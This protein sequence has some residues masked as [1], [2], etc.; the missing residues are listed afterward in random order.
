MSEP[1]SVPTVALLLE[2]VRGIV[3]WD[4]LGGHLGLESHEIKE[5][6]SNYPLVA[7]R[8]LEMLDLWL[9]RK[10]LNPSWEKIITALQK[11]SELTLAARLQKKYIQGCQ[12]TEKPG[13][14]LKVHEKDKVVQELEDI[15]G[16][17]LRLV[18]K[19]E[20]ALEDESIP[21]RDLRRF[22]KFYL[23]RLELV[24]AVSTVEELFDKLAPY[25]CFLNYTL[26]KRAINMFLKHTELGSHLSDYQQLLEEFKK[27]TTLQ[28]FMENIERAQ[29]LPGTVTDGKELCTVTIRLVGGWL[30]KTVQNL[31]R[32]VEELF[33]DKSSVLAHLMICPGSII[34]TY[35][36]PQLEA[37]SL[38]A[39]AREKVSFMSQV[40][41]CGLQVGETVVTSMQ[42]GTSPF[43][44]ESSLIGAVENDDLMLLS[45]LLDLN[46]SPDAAG[47]EE[48]QTALMIGSCRGKFEAVN[49]LLKANADPNLH[50]GDGKTALFVASQH[51][52][53]EVVR[54]LLNASANPNLPRWDGATALFMASQNGHS[55]AV[56]LLLNANANPNLRWKDG[57]TALAMASL[58]GHSQVVRLLLRSNV[59]CNPN[60]QADDGTS[61]LMMASHN[62]HTEIVDSLLKGNANPNL[63]MNDGATALH[64]AGLN[65]LSEIVSLLLKADADPNVRRH[66]GATALIFASGKG[67]Q[68]IVHRLLRAKANTS[69]KMEHGITA[70]IFATAHK[71]AEVVDLLLSADADPN[72]RTNDGA[73]ALHLAT[74]TGNPQIVT[75]LLKAN[76][77]PDL[78][79]GGQGPTALILASEKGDI[80][81]VD[82]LLESNA[83]PNIPSNSGV[84]ALFM[85][86]QNGHTEVV[87][88]LLKANANPD[89]KR[90]L[91]VTPLYMASQKGYSEIVHLL[92]K[93]NANPNL[94]TDRGYTALSVASFHGHL[95]VVS[96]LLNS[97]AN[98][99]LQ[100]D[101]GDT[102]LSVASKNG[103]L[104]VVT[105]LL[106][107]SVSDRDASPGTQVETI[108]PNVNHQGQ[109]GS[110]A[111]M[112]A[113]P[114][115]EVVE[116]LLRHGAKPNIQDKK[117]WT[118]LMTACQDG[119][120]ETAELLLTSGADPNLQNHIGATALILATYYGHQDTVD[121]LQAMELSLFSPVPQDDTLKKTETDPESS[122]VRPDDDAPVVEPS[123]V[124]LRTLATLV[125]PP[126]IHYKRT[127]SNQALIQEESSFNQ[128]M[129]II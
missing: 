83:N 29:R 55:E 74:T 12:V 82:L 57:T 80:R 38:I 110:T 93:S 126:A 108:T 44:F 119:N 89:L 69:F 71:H 62:G 111:L 15:E 122:P 97:N 117:G 64:L 39:F 78:R 76:A 20:S 72:Q 49:L 100:A 87:R 113:H 51:G 77:N 123:S 17:F 41:I 92:L 50:K 34:V 70:L 99:N 46:T 129:I 8:R 98:P 121:L 63:Q 24:A 73:T 75:L 43:S 91:G 26:L 30:P 106:E 16:E 68:N 94:Q 127:F 32:L 52:H 54:L 96:Q 90:D 116:V 101:D 21:M 2:E 14:D 5:I 6:E 28:Q 18:V 23:V 7:R 36:A 95:E 128:P 88:L 19:I 9:N 125:Q 25:Y 45:F 35:F 79:G 66:D 33:Q 60:H 58:K 107:G 42:N 115:P 114:H 11:M 105:L 67:H 47:G 48:G 56:T 81:I 109:G 120:L 1:V 104:G 27:S 59:Y 22:A 118:A 10:E 31:E 102:A 4:I 61:A 112:Q 85:A 13:K 53:S 84:T 65:G 86:S 124:P 103:H 3:E 40:G 37:D